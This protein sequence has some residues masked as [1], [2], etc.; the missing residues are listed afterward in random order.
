MSRATSIQL[1]LT[2]RTPLATDL[3]TLDPPCVFD[4]AVVGGWEVFVFAIHYQWLRFDK[5][6][7]QKLFMD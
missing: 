6:I 1:Q 7:C 3:T 5:G 2:V 4:P